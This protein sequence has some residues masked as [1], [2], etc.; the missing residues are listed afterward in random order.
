MPMQKVLSGYFE[1]RLCEEDYELDRVPEQEALCSECH[2]KL[3][4]RDEEETVVSHCACLRHADTTD[5]A[6]HAE[7]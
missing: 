2:V 7:P 3:E 1:C 6:H 4:E 5:S